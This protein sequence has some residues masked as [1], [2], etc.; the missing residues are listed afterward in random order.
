MKRNAVAG[1]ISSMNECDMQFSKKM[2][3]K[4]SKTNSSTRGCYSGSGSFEPSPPP[5]KPYE[6][7][8][9]R[10]HVKIFARSGT[11]HSCIQGLSLDP[12]R[13]LKQSPTSHPDK[14]FTCWKSTDFWYVSLSFPKQFTVGVLNSLLNRCP[15]LPRLLVSQSG[16][17]SNRLPI[18]SL[19]L[20]AV[21]LQSWVNCVWLMVS[22]SLDFSC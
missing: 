8:Q 10:S 13:F 20:G 4:R 22:D 7:Y 17:F 18:I 2:K 3:Q 21:G 1:T 15:A 9:A 5:M 11:L 19:S 12:G 6:T 16:W 14:A